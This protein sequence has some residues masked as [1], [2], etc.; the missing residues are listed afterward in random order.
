MTSPSELTAYSGVVSAF[1]GQGELS[2][3]KRRLL[4]EL[5][6]ALGVP[7]DRHRAEVRRAANDESLNTIAHRCVPRDGGGGGTL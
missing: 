6:G 7:A 4:A 5:A 2:K 1:R 3:E